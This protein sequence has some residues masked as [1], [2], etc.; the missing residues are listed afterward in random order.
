[1]STLIM[2]SD[3]TVVERFQSYFASQF[4]EG[5]LIWAAQVSPPVWGHQAL[6]LVVF[7][8]RMR[9]TLS[10]FPLIQKLL[11][12]TPALWLAYDGVSGA[13]DESLEGGVLGQELLKLDGNQLT[14]STVIAGRERAIELH[15]AQKQQE[16]LDT[17][18]APGNLA[19]VLHHLIRPMRSECSGLRQAISWTRPPEQAQGNPS[20]SD[21]TPLWSAVSARA[22]RLDQHLNRFED[23]ISL[24]GNQHAC[25]RQAFSLG[26]VIR[27]VAG[28]FPSASLHDQLMQSESSTESTLAFADP[29]Q[30][31][32]CLS[33]ILATLSRTEANQAQNAVEI[34][35][36]RRGHQWEVI[37]TEAGDNAEISGQAQEAFNELQRVWNQKSLATA[38][39]QPEFL[40]GL[41]LTR[42]RARHNGGEVDL[43][44]SAEQRLGIR[45]VLPLNDLTSVLSCYQRFLTRELPELDEV[46]FVWVNFSEKESQPSQ[47]HPFARFIQ[48]RLNSRVMGL[49]FEDGN[50]LMIAPVSAQEEA[51]FTH[52]IQKEWSAHCLKMKPTKT[53][54]EDA[55]LVLSKLISASVTAPIETWVTQFQHDFFEELHQDLQEVAVQISDDNRRL[56][57]LQTVGKS[58]PRPQRHSAVRRPN[59]CSTPSRD[60]SVPQS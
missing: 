31:R 9:L 5:Q 50:W 6:E 18:V 3:W 46:A 20:L 17:E 16:H 25:H 15:R 8:S 43:I 22:D 12:E 21:D 57:Q 32:S 48:S 47:R 26:P 41:G 36:Q 42:E 4:A 40:M 37:V 7:D 33:E 38:C 56:H 10:E 11:E 27:E 35:L 60:A 1:M 54:T 23:L 24:L 28:E 45:L 51:S 2:T 55:K 49:P 19:Q 34:E 30:I 29:Q 52:W 13:F 59:F 53:S 39:Q 14:L 44:L 58:T